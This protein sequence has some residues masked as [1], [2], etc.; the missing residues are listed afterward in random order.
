ME[1]K[2]ID[3]KKAQHPF[4]II[5]GILLIAA[6]ISNFIPAGVYDRIVDE[7]GRTVVDPDTFHYV[8]GVKFSITNL[9]TSIPRGIIQAA[10]VVVIT[11]SIGG[12][13]GVIKETGILEIGVEKLVEVFGDK[14]I[15]IIY[16]LTFAFA[17]V[18]GFIGTPELAIVYIPVLMPLFFRLGFDSI[19][20]VGLSL[21][22]TA[23]GFSAAW[24]APATVGVGHELAEL[25]LY[26][27]MNVRLIV[28]VVMAVVGATYIAIYARKILKDPTRSVTYE[29]DKELRAKF[30]NDNSQF[31]S[32]YPRANLAGIVTIILFIGM[33]A[34]VVTF[35]WGFEEMSGYLIV[36]GVIIG[37]TAG[38]SL[39][40]TLYALESGLKDMLVGALITGIARGISVVLMDAQVMDTIIMFLATF[41]VRLPA[42]IA[43][44]GMLWVTSIFNA[45]V[46]SGSGKAVISLPIM[47][48]IGDMAEVSRQTA[49]LAYQLGDGITN[50][51]WPASGY[52]MAA[53][54]IGDTD[55]KTWVKWVMP[56][57]IIW[58]ILAS[59][60]VAGA[61]MMGY[62]PF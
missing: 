33:I 51:L 18:C 20:T 42:E 25:P 4:I 36:M 48:P 55:Y 15:A 57:I 32:K 34:G 47:I 35:S 41:V 54:A 6:L 39:N 19:T 29:K 11:L 38:M 14:R 22:S 27:G 40:N 45:I 24:T 37:L 60:I 30:E 58:M 26:S 5:V 1:K 8:D 49:I 2:N 28:A 9:M 7:A 23:A 56:L 46:A 43:S 59:F 3:K 21:I 17:S 12:T 31:E 62:G 50:I 61:S 10:N 44:V 53:L 13:F 16:I 52:F